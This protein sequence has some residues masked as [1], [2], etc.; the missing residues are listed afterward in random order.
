[1]VVDHKK[2]AKRKVSDFGSNEQQLKVFDSHQVI[3]CPQCMV[4]AGQISHEVVGL[5]C[6]V[7]FIEI[8][9]GHCHNTKH[10]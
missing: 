4:C 6:L 7:V 1:M 2:E 9:L 5:L 8:Y 10:D 3:R